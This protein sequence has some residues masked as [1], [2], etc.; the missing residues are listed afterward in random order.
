M[1]RSD[2]MAMIKQWEYKFQRGKHETILRRFY[3]DASGIQYVK[4][5]GAWF[6]LTDYIYSDYHEVKTWYQPRI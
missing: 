4:V 1:K 6:K 5:L 2:R 3:E